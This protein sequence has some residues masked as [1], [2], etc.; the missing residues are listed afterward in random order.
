MAAAG[1]NPFIVVGQV[2]H[3]RKGTHQIVGDGVRT[4]HLSKASYRPTKG[5]F[6]FSHTRL[7]GYAAYECVQRPPT[8]SGRSEDEPGSEAKTAEPW[9]LRA[10]LSSQR[11]LEWRRRACGLTP[12]RLQGLCR[13]QRV[14]AAAYVD[15]RAGERPN[16]IYYARASGRFCPRAPRIG[17]R[18]YVHLTVSL[19]W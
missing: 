2:Y 11:R 5:R 1:R 8:Q 12:F 17:R 7:V 16:R 9:T 3:T 10:G 14:P 13:R 19:W 18:P 4:V 15:L 6:V